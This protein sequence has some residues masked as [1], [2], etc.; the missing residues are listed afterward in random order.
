MTIKTDRTKQADK[1]KELRYLRRRVRELEARVVQLHRKL[2][3][4][5]K[6]AGETRQGG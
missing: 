4:Y 1:D 5:Q 6:M 3:R 2:T